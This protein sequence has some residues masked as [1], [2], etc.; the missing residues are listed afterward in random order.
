MLVYTGNDSILSFLISRILLGLYVRS[1]G[2]R[3]FPPQVIY[4]VFRISYAVNYRNIRVRTASVPEDYYVPP[5]VS[6]MRLLTRVVILKVDVV[7]SVE[8]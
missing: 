3:T 6:N 7:L 1:K 5:V 4:V 8:G 2:Y